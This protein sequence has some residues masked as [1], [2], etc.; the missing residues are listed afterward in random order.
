MVYIQTYVRK[1][2]KKYHYFEKEVMCD[3]KAYIE[4]LK[5]KDTIEEFLQSDDKRKKIYL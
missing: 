5:E 1:I 4:D 3:F 2:A